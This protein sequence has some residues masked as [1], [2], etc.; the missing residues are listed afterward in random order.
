[1]TRIQRIEK[2]LRRSRADRDTARR[3]TRRARSRTFR[4]EALEDRRLLASTASMASVV[5]ANGLTSKTGTVDTEGVA[6]D[7]AGNCYITGNFTGMVA[8]GTNGTIPLLT[9]GPEAD[10]YLAK[11]SPAGTVLWAK[12]LGSISSSDSN[13]GRN[14]AVDASGNVYMTGWFAAGPS[15]G[16]DVFVGKF[17]TANGNTVWAESFGGSGTDEGQDIAVDTSGNV[18]LTGFYQQ[19]A[20]F[21]TVKLTSLGS[22]DIFVAKLNSAGTVQWAKSM[23]GTGDDRAL[24]LSIDA[25]GD[26]FT[27]GI[28]SLTATFGT[29]P[30][31]NTPNTLTSNGST[32]IFVAKMDNNGN[33]LWAEGYGG[34]GHDDGTAVAADGT[35]G[36]FF[37]GDMVGNVTFNKLL[38]NASAGNVTD[39]AVVG[40]INNS[41]AV[42]WAE[43]FGGPGYDA[44]FDIT[45]ANGYVYTTGIFQGTGSFPWLGQVLTS[46]GGYNV[47]LANIDPN[48]GKVNY[49]QSFGSTGADQAWHI[50]VGGPNNMITTV[51]D[52]GGWVNFGYFGLPQP[53]GGASYVVQFT[54][55]PSTATTKVASDFDAIGKTELAYYV[56]STQ[57]WWVRG[58]NGDRLMATYGLATGT[59]LPVT[60]DFL[61]TGRPQMG[62]YDTA[63]GNWWVLG[64]NNVVQFLGNFGDPKQKDIPVPGNYDGPGKT[65]LAVYRPG[66]GQWFV[67]GPHGWY[68]KGF[69]DPT[70]KD[71]PVP[72]DYDGVGYTELAVYRP[73]SA[74]WYVLGPRGW[75]YMGTFGQPNLVTGYGDVPIPGDYDGIGRT[76]PAVYR[77]TTAMFLVWRPTGNFSLGT[78]FGYGY[79]YEIPTQ[80]AAGELLNLG[81]LRGVIATGL[82]SAAIAAPAAGV[83]LAADAQTS[84]GTA[85]KPT[86]AAAPVPPATGSAASA[87]GLRPAVVARQGASGSKSRTDLLASA[88]DHLYDD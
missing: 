27:T 17:N 26:V 21:G 88:L 10:A 77:P 24:G 74:Q 61:G 32:D 34:T 44:G 87:P 58:P 73:A 41:G 63:T 3:G 35:G 18:Y 11:I 20:T 12:D 16:R 31:T 53:S 37:T 42:T 69:G 1:V 79:F 81:K 80:A 46:N 4:L 6:M 39:D 54:E 68:G 9:Q 23:G 14:V 13:Q 60:G 50:A 82:R 43:N 8:F 65:E 55:T 38:I 22:N 51:G 29:K 70:Q 15:T 86:T 78:W 64:P 71:I 48:S 45:Y 30:G 25:L 7:S 56:P 57:Q 75:Y 85:A 52:Y 40:H 36:V 83:A 49:A 33:V 19:T 84:S 76:Q 5:F 59:G 2:S 67:L 47:Y 72:G 66:T 28:F 62:M